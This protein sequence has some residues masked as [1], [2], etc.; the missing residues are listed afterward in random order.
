MKPG[1]TP[2]RPQPESS[3]EGK[4][5]GNSTLSFDHLW[6]FKFI[7]FLLF[8]IPSI[9]FKILGSLEERF[10]QQN[11]HLYKTKRGN[12]SEKV[13][14]KLEEIQE[15]RV[16]STQD[17]WRWCTGGIAEA[18]SDRKYC[19]KKGAQL[20]DGDGTND[21][22]KVS[23]RFLLLTPR[24]WHFDQANLITYYITYYITLLIL[25]TFLLAHWNTER[26][27]SKGRSSWESELSS[28]ETTS[29]FR[30]WTTSSGRRWEAD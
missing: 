21:Q 16:V 7:I 20:W 18:T 5:G 26:P 10:D 14:E 22:M 11:V 25:K 3:L 24:T 8:L 27:V 6:F 19:L 9:S 13:Q 12:E 23:D 15:R 4:I 17:N 30:C 28:L 2:R 29:I 1:G